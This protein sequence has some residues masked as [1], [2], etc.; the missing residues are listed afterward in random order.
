MA[1]LADAALAEAANSSSAGEHH[2][3]SGQDTDN[4]FQK[5]ISAWRSRFSIPRYRANA[6]PSKTSTSRP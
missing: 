1:D 4:K 5:A 3:A 6:N 2:G